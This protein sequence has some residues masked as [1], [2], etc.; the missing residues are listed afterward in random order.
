MYNHKVRRIRLKKKRI[1]FSAAVLFLIVLV[2]SGLKAVN[3]LNSISTREAWV[4]ELPS[5][6]RGERVNFLVTGIDYLEDGRLFADQ[7]VFISC[8]PKD[9]TI[10][11]LYLPGDTYVNIKDYGWE[12]LGRVYTLETTDKRASLLIDLVS[13]IAGLPVHYFVEINYRGMPEI[14]NSFKE[15]DLDIKKAVIQDHRIAFPEGKYVLKGE[16]VYKYLTFRCD[17]DDYL[18]RLERQRL[19]FGTLIKEINKKGLFGLPGIMGRLSPYVQSNLNWRETV[20]YYNLF[21]DV[22]YEEEVALEIIPGKYEDLNG[23]GVWKVDKEEFNNVLEH[24]FM[25]T[26]DEVPS[27]G[28]IKVEIL[29]GTGKTDSASQA[30]EMLRERGYEIIKSGNADHFDYQQS[31]VIS[32]IE[33]IEPAKD[34]AVLIPGSQ[35]LKETIDDYEA[36]VTIIIGHNYRI[37][38]E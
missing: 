16:E 27:A 20:Y 32:R 37:I 30:A 25:E 11:V 4:S 5:V 3:L 38:Y 23:V 28:S 12:R 35:L 1:V 13:K 18:E 22:D 2:V 19:F 24:L 33:D 26:E 29:N 31:Q 34:I 10:S 8:S 15:I 14:V 7:V 17:D 6:N 9:D 36:Q 21:Q